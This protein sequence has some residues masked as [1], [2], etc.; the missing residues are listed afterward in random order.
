MYFIPQNIHDDN[1]S[2]I[3]A[4]NMLNNTDTMLIELTNQKKTRLMEELELIK[5]LRENIELVCCQKTHK[6]I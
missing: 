4:K 1:K 2:C 6:F 5:I 3:F